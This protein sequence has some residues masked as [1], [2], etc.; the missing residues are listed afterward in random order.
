MKFCRFLY[1]N[2]P[3]FG[4][5]ESVGGTDTITRLLN[6]HLFEAEDLDDLPTMKI[7]GVPLAGAQLLA[8]VTPQ[9]IVCIGRNYAEHAKELGNLVPT[10]D[11]VLFFKPPSSL[12]GSNGVVKRPPDSERVD[13]EGEL[14]VVIRRECRH[15]GEGDDINEYI[16]GYTI[17]NDVTARDLQKKDVQWVRGKGYDTFCPVGPVVVTDPLDTKAGVPLETRVNGQVKQSG[18]TRDF[19]FPLDH[20]LRYITR[21]M[22]LY[23]GDLIAT[24]TPAGVGPVVAGDVMEISVEGIGTLRNPVEDEKI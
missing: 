18:N 5:V 19:I 12:I 13:Y 17:V 14:G 4:L 9:K 16:L 24:G 2:K 22:T 21:I 20:Q 1:N 15:L 11:M 3:Q 23:P 7:P 10:E 8:P 6:A